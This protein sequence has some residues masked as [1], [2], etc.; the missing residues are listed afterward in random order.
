[1]PKYITMILYWN[2]SVTGFTNGTNGTWLPVNP[3][4]WHENL[5]MLSKFKSHLRTY[6]Q[7]ARLR[8]IPTIIKGDLHVY[9]LSKWVFGFSR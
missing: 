9:V 5:V 2:V 1:M 3:D 7:L 4:Y 8:Q 6:R